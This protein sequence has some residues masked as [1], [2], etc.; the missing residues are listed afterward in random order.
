[1]KKPEN[2]INQSVNKLV[3]AQLDDSLDAIGDSTLQKLAAARKKAILAA[4][5]SA[6][7]PSVTS[8]SK[9][10][11]S[12]HKPMWAMAASVCLALPIWYALNDQQAVVAGQE[13]T[14]IVDLQAQASPQGSQLAAIDSPLSAQSTNLTTL[15][16]MTNLASLDEDELEIL[17]DLE[18][19]LWLGE[20]GLGE[21]ALQEQAPNQQG[22]LGAQPQSAH[23]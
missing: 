10:Q 3:K 7:Q 4:Q 6:Q 5:H 8:I 12:W 16:I 22:A 19:A 18:F 13:M 17:E 1:M 23:G 14:S 20:R 2:D 11:T 9:A 15:D 21:R